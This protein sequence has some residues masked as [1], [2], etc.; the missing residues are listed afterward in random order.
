MGVWIP[1][2]YDLFIFSD[3][4]VRV[5]DKSFILILYLQVL[6]YILIKICTL[7]GIVTS[8]YHYHRFGAMRTITLSAYPGAMS[9]SDKK[10][11][12]CIL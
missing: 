2:F 8:P 6:R 1:T 9:E 4:V 3:T 10:N 11:R 12:Q 5:S 7:L